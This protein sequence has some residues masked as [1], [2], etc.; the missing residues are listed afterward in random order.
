[1]AGDSHTTGIIPSPGN[2]GDGPA[3]ARPP[4][5]TLAA[6]LV[7][8][9]SASTKSSK[10]DEN[11]E[12][13]GFF[14]IIQRVKDDPGLL[15][16]PEER[17]EHNHMLIYVYSRVVLEGIKFD[18]PFLDRTLVRTEALKAINFLRFTIKETP[19]VLNYK[20]TG[21]EFLFRGSEALWVWLFPHLLRLLGH[22]QCNELSEDIEGL[23]QYLLLVVAQTGAL[24]GLAP[25]MMLYLRTTLT[26][27]V[28]PR[29]IDTNINY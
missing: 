11:S 28:P 1:M 24:W 2:P 6:Q 29:S 7:E 12:L 21:D 9:I 23:F 14:A 26:S 3:N 15:K 17:V 20:I 22:S 4:P 25:A 5:S 18:D 16:T 8:N 19:R 13:K 27:K 10:S